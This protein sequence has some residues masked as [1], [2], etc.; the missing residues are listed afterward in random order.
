MKIYHL[1]FFLIF[2]IFIISITIISNENSD[3]ANIKRKT[4]AELRENKIFITCGSTIRL[5]NYLTDT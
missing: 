4:E 2:V 1:Q 5:R 3:E